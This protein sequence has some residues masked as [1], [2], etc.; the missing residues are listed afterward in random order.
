MHLSL[1]QLHGP[2]ELLFETSKKEERRGRMISQLSVHKNCLP[3]E[4]DNG[5]MYYFRVTYV[6]Y[7][8]FIVK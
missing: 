3:F 6:I 1:L 8:I 4:K 7:I 2:L 5:I